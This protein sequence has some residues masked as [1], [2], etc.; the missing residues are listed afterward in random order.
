MFFLIAPT[1][2]AGAF[3]LKV[4]EG[5]NWKSLA[6]TMLT[7]AG[8]VQAI[9]LTAAC[10]FIEDAAS[11][12]QE[13]LSA[14]PADKEVEK[15]DAESARKATHLR[16]ATEWRHV[17]FVMR[18]ILLVGTMA[19]VTSAGAL[20]IMAVDCFHPFELTSKLK[21]PPT[22]GKIINV[23]KPLGLQAMKLFCFSLVC[24]WIFGI[25]ANHRA[26]R[27]GGNHTAARSRDSLVLHADA[28]ESGSTGVQIEMPPPIRQA[29][30]AVDDTNPT[31]AAA[32]TKPAVTAS[33]KLARDQTSL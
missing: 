20:Q 18:G 27:A 12:H 14:I 8:L 1:C 29:A 21:D 24:L 30:A 26:K 16:A 9:A 4:S 7:V 31:L 2:A 11:K 3:Q 22:N 25:W 15:A 32:L 17:P 5:G 19:A 33:Q 13:E 28:E 10:Y 6:D 23:L